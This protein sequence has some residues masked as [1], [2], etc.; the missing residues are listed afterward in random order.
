M[1]FNML[2]KSW[3]LDISSII[4]R[5]VGG[6]SKNTFLIQGKLRQKGFIFIMS[7]SYVIC[8]MSYVI[9]HMLNPL[10]LI[11]V[12]NYN[13][14]LSKIHYLLTQAQYST[15]LLGRFCENCD[16]LNRNFIRL[17]REAATAAEH[18][19]TCLFRNIPGRNALLNSAP[20]K[21]KTAEIALLWVVCYCWIIKTIINRPGVAGAVLHTASLLIH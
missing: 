12:M 10:G 5:T 6:T 20:V 4:T 11:L 18:S 9:C 16:E 13:T 15:V 21:L 7:Y 8:H 3:K 19:S 2:R 17:L 1:N 14:C